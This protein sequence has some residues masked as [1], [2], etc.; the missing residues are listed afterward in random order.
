MCVRYEAGLPCVLT[1]NIAGVQSRLEPMMD[2][3]QQAGSSPEALRRWQKL[4]KED[5]TTS[6]EMTVKSA[7]KWT[8]KWPVAWRRDSLAMNKLCRDWMY[9]GELWEILV[10]LFKFPT[11][12][13]AWSLWMEMI[14]RLIQD[15]RCYD[16]LDLGL[17]GSRRSQRREKLPPICLGTATF[18]W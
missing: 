6:E 15:V 2:V 7:L 13:G 9:V 12:P 10:E 16:R 1:T 17:D 18:S 4:G 8:L 5:S 14:G 11:R 3:D